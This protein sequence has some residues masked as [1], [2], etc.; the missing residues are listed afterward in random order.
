[1]KTQSILSLVLALAFI[2]VL[3]LYLMPN[4]FAGIGTFYGS[5]AMLAVMFLFVFVFLKYAK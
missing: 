5:I 2:I 4:I 3:V 1:M